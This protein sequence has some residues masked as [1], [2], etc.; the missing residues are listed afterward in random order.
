MALTEKNK[1]E[2]FDI[3][4]EYIKNG[5]SLRTALKQ[6]DSCKRHIWDEL[7]II[8]GNK[9][10]YT[11]AREERADFIFEEILAIA[12]NSGNDRKIIK[13]GEEVINHEAIQRD[14]LRVDARKWAASKMNP[15]KY[16]DKT[17]VEHSGEIKGE[18]K[19][20]NIIVGDKEIDLGT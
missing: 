7:V 12:D 10:Q 14:R 5:M 20:I 3:T 9:T 15:K 16:G 18:S 11:C 13:D 19:T 1:Q 6:D 17:E 2:L 4:L 8:E